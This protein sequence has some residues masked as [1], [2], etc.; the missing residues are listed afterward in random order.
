MQYKIFHIVPNQLYKKEDGYVSFKKFTDFLEEKLKNSDTLRAKFYRFVLKHFKKNPE[1]L[2]P[3]KITALEKY[4]YIFDLLEGTIL[5]YLSNEKE[6]ALALGV[7]M[8]PLFFL[9]N[10]RKKNSIIC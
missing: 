9:I 4:R 6:F 8:N 1:L 5:P 10:I 2:A 7:P 3:I